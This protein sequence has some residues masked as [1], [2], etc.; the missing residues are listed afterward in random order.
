M[1]GPRNWE[2]VEGKEEQERK[3]KK[4]ASIYS[5]LPTY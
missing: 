5:I 2:E 4:E 3:R 1:G